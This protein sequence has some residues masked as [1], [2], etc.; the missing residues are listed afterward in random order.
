MAYY[1]IADLHLSANNLD[2]LEAFDTFVS[3]LNFNDRLIIA[4]DLFNFYVGLDKN[5]I[6]QKS[7][8]RTLQKAN[9]RGIKSYFIRGN[10]DFLMKHVDASFFSMTLVPD[11]FPIQS[12]LGTCI[13]MHGDLLCTNDKKHLKFRKITSK[14]WLQKLFL[15]LPLSWRNRIGN[16]IRSKSNSHNFH[17]LDK[18]I[19]EVV[20][21][22]IKYFLHLYNAKNII[23]GH[24]H[25]LENVSNEF[26]GENLRL[27]VNAWGS[28]YS[29]VRID[30]NGIAIVEKNIDNLLKNHKI[31]SK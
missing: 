27:C 15:S 2:L 7:V 20:P 10:R 19:F 31:S 4:G 3:E 1:I 13:I 30:L 26:K 18:S 25:R 22:T 16:K 23:H 28:T 17:K 12:P 9:E 11:I 24:I 29:Y 8:A 14:K 5:N 6:A 21:N